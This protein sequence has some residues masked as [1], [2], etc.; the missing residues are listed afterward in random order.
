VVSVWDPACIARD[1]PYLGEPIKGLLGQLILL[2]VVLQVRD[3]ARPHALE[4]FQCC[5]HL[6]CK[7][8]I[9]RLVTIEGGVGVEGGAGG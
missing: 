2:A 4:V 1:I 8:S 3:D 7:S 5:R 9:A 6:A